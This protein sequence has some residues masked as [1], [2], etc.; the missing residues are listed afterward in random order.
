[1]S[2]KM[3]L[4]LR[5]VTG[6][7]FRTFRAESDSPPPTAIAAPKLRVAESEFSNSTFEFQQHLSY[8]LDLEACLKA[9]TIAASGRVEPVSTWCPSK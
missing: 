5:A 7:R 9:L 3:V 6:D 8:S 4:E 1:M 2:R